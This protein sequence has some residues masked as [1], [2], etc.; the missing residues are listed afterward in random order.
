[1][2]SEKV[3]EYLD[4]E[5]PAMTVQEIETW[6]ISKAI[7]GISVQQGLSCESCNYCAGNRNV[8]KNHFS[9]SHQGSKRSDWT[10]ECKIQKVFKGQFHCKCTG[11]RNTIENYGTSRRRWKHWKI[12]RYFVFLIIV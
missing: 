11:T 9:S 4:L 3:I 1:M 5:I 8:M 10:K 2:T 12:L 6:I 7:A